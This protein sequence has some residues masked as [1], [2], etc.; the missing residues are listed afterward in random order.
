M[1]E[2]GGGKLEA[3]APPDAEARGRGAGA[4]PTAEAVDL[5]GGRVAR[6]LETKDGTADIDFVAVTLIVCAAVESVAATVAVWVVVG[7]ED[8]N[9]GLTETVASRLLSELIT[10]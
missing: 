2:E 1:I 3:R 5:A 4:V 6:V 10:L 7:A 8:E 9:E